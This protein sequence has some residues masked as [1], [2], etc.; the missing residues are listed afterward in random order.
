MV[1]GG[2]L[3]DMSDNSFYLI[4]LAGMLIVAIATFG[5]LL[6]LFIKKNKENVRLRETI[7][8]NDITERQTRERT[9]QL[10]MIRDS[11]SEYAVQKFELVQELEDKNKHIL[12]QKDDIQKK[13][14][15]LKL[16][17]EEIRKLDKFKHQITT[18]I[19]HDIKNPLNVLI[20]VAE[21]KHIEPKT[22][23]I[24]KQVSYEM[25]DLVL[26]LLDVNKINDCKMKINYENF[27]LA[28][29]LDKIVKKY[30]VLIAESSAHLKIKIPEPC[31]I[32]SDFKII[33]RVIENL[34]MNAI[35]HTTSESMIEILA[36]E[37]GDKIRIEIRDNG[38]GIPEELRK[39][40]FDEY[41]H[42]LDKSIKYANSTGLG[43]T[44]CKLAVEAQGGMIGITSKPGVGTAVWFL[45]NIGSDKDLIHHNIHKEKTEDQ[46]S[47]LL[48]QNDTSIIKPIIE[49][50][51]KTNIFQV[52][53][54]ILLLENEV[55]KQNVNLA[56]WKEALEAAVYSADEN[57][58]RTLLGRINED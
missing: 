55:F 6:Y 30:S 28:I 16:V 12:M 54:I 53:D 5:V 20:N 34:L 42:G 11:I 24:I 32:N 57:L 43:L 47:I 51:S 7:T 4:L 10:E 15:K 3:H 46:K 36:K 22:A 44:Y 21:N 2:N 23:G 38:D 31:I 48:D 9:K 33:E 35:K 39:T 25:L 18:W 8:K 27:E 26:N 37:H 58:F 52:S 13:S 41:V 14:E 40:L 1:F 50:L 56:N 49:K 29:L 19:I 45:T 17:N